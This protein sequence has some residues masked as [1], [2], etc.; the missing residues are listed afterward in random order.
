M[1]LN[2]SELKEVPSVE[3][4]DFLASFEN[5]IIANMN[6]HT[7]TL[8]DRKIEYY[9]TLLTGKQIVSYKILPYIIVLYFQTNARIQVEHHLFDQLLN[10]IPIGSENIKIFN[11]INLTLQTW[12]L[13]RMIE[14]RELK[15]ET[16]GDIRGDVATSEVNDIARGDVKGE[17]RSDMRGEMRGVIR[18]DMRGDMKGD[19]KG[20]VKGDVKGVVKGD[21]RD[22]MRGVIRGDVKGIVRGDVKVVMKDDIRGIVKKI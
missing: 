2:L 3:G 1:S 13:D 11:F 18:G 5:G 10:L 9:R 7:T 15:G 4:T 14:E 21:M 6:K 17:M 8:D 22:V 20:I 19:V 16:R 12:T